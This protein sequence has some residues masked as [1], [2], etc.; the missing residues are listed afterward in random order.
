MEPEFHSIHNV[1]N[2]PG[3]LVP[4]KIYNNHGATFERRASVIFPP[5]TSLR[6]A[7]AR[8]F[9][10]DTR[11]QQ[12]ISTSDPSKL[13]FTLRL[14]WPGYAPWNC[15]IQGTERA[16][17]SEPV[18]LSVLA[19]RVAHAVEKFLAKSVQ[20]N[21]D[22]PPSKP[23]WNVDAIRFEGLS[24][25]ELRHVSEGSWQPVLSYHP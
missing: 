5:G 6:R 2:A 12:R 14:E 3:I 22:I 21:A 17:H 23:G 4:Q 19:E 8:A 7:L 25:V 16:G 18:L 10:N 13:K 9:A 11:F 1:P 20:Q 15:N 24:L